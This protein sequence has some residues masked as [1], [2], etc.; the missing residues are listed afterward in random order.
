MYAKACLLLKD[1]NKGKQKWTTERVIT[2]FWLTLVIS[3]LKIIFLLS[4]SPYSLDNW[5]TSSWTVWC[6]WLFPEVLSV[7]LD[8]RQLPIPHVSRLDVADARW[9]WSLGIV[10]ASQCYC[11]GGCISWYSSWQ[12]VCHGVLYMRYNKC[13]Q[14]FITISPSCQVPL[15]GDQCG[16]TICSYSTPYR[17]PC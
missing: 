4:M 13:K 14:D 6:S 8:A 17:V 1:M 3:F 16:V 12:I 10:R 5:G 11:H 15:I 2:F 9:D 7:A